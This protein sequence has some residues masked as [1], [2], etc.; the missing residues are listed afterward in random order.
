MKAT[1]WENYPA[2]SLTERKLACLSPRKTGLGVRNAGENAD[3][4]HPVTKGSVPRAG[5]AAL[6]VC[7]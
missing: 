1:R 2:R 3:G 6:R 4:H 7:T 5:A